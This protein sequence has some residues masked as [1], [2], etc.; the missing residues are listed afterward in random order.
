MQVVLKV[1][2]R[3]PVCLLSLALLLLPCSSKA[4]PSIYALKSYAFFAS[5]LVTLVNP[6][7]HESVA[8][9]TVCERETIH[10]HTKDEIAICVTALLGGYDEV[11]HPSYEYRVEVGGFTAW[12]RAGTLVV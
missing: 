9:G 6:Q 3:T 11:I 10:G 4:E 12:W 7:D 2:N 1:K 8:E 5:L